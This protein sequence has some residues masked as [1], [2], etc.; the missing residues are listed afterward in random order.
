MAT[1]GDVALRAGVSI[2]TVSR[3]VNND[4]Y[5]SDGV[6]QRVQQA[7]EDTHYVPNLLAK[8]FRL[9]R[10]S[11]IGIAVP[12]LAL[13]CRDLDSVDRRDPGRWPRE[14]YHQ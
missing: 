2:K 7:I 8:S 10:D 14:T 12:D 9:G 13:R 11:A 4:D 3:V 6:R 1:M 5:I